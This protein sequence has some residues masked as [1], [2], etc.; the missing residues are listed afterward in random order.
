MCC[1][2]EKAKKVEVQTVEELTSVLKY[3]VKQKYF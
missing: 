1:Q 2:R 3:A